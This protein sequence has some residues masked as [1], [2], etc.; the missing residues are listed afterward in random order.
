VRLPDSN[1]A[2]PAASLMSLN[3]FKQQFA[4]IQ[5]LSNQAACYQQNANNIQIGQ[6]ET[7]KLQISTSN[8]Q[9]TQVNKL[10]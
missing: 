8:K 9:F 6:N 7:N 1:N 3:S 10:K 4:T 2:N 5:I